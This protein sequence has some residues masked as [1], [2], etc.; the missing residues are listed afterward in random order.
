MAVLQA[1]QKLLVLSDSLY[2][3]NALGFF[4][5][6]GNVAMRSNFSKIVGENEKGRVMGL[7][8]MLMVLITT[9]TYSLLTINY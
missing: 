2:I 8:A 1:S 3:A 5:K 4:Y 6:T 7:A 9:N